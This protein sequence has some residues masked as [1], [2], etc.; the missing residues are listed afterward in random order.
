MSADKPVRIA[1][2][3]HTN[4][5]K[6]SLLRTLAH[7]TDFGEVSDRPGTTRDVRGVVLNDEHGEPVVEMYDTPGLEDAVG[8]MAFI[9]Q[10]FVGQPDPAAEIEAFVSSDHGGGRYEQEAKVLRQMLRS[11]AAVYV[12]DVREP[13]LT[14]HREELR[15]LAA[16]GRPVMPLLNF[17]ASVEANAVSWREQLSRVALHVVAEFDTVVFDSRAE[18]V[19]FEKLGSLLEARRANFAKLISA[20]EK[21]RSDQI[22]V[23]CRAIAELIVNTAGVRVQYEE[24]KPVEPA[25][26]RLREIVRT[27]EQ[28]CVNAL[29]E[30][31]R[32]DLTTHDPPE[33][34]LEHGKWT[35]DVFD[36]ETLRTYGIRIASNA[37]KG[38][39]AGM[40]VDLVTG[41]VSLGAATA[42]G[43]GLGA[44]WDLGERVLMPILKGQ[45]EFKELALEEGTL[46]VLAARQVLLL[47]A[48]LRRGHATQASLKTSK[49][50][51]WPS[52]EIRKAASRCRSHPE[53]S[54][55]NEL[56]NTALPAEAVNPLM[57]ALRQ[58][59][60]P[61]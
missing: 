25:V 26:Q 5:G 29:L 31:F 9:K 7:D 21:Q 48:L 57:R 49:T 56:A 51:G 34:P 10:N 55:L 36:P 1:V 39:A 12:I 22:E 30:N 11:D 47:R 27:A 52:V 16:C 61:D 58:I 41:M 23:A 3:G 45:E 46:A 54:A 40:A 15:L 2:V 19:V 13:M 4:T 20:R 28:R 43:A 14:K 44:L 60:E 37:A 50:A 42:I 17:V 35:L 33:L 53:W 6:T 24:T 8:L 18:R 38:A 32:F 59:S